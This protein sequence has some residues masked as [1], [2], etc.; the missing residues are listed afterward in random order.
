[1]PTVPKDDEGVLGLGAWEPGQELLQQ[2]GCLAIG[3][4]PVD[5]AD[6]GPVIA[7]KVEEL[8]NV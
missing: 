8:V 2:S 7:Q 3:S 5:K 4:Q 6:T 1:M